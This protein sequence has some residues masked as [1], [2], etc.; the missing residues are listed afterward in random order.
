MRIAPLWSCL[1]LLLPGCAPAGLPAARTAPE[2]PPSAEELRSALAQ[3]LP[4]QVDGMGVDYVCPTVTR[5]ECAPLREGRRYQ[6]SFRDERGRRGTALVALRTD[7]DE[8][9][10]YGRWRWIRGSLSCGSY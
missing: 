4:S 5:L 10:D 1:G 7:P 6:C 8:R 2:P 3:S 9:R